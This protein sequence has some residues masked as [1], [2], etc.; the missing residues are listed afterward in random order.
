[1]P[2]QIYLFALLQHQTSLFAVSVLDILVPVFV[3][4]LIK[5]EVTG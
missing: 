1:M 2:P 4:I 3:Q 5:I